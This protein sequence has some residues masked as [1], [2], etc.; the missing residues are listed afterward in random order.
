[1][2]VP[3]FEGGTDDVKA[4]K[5]S[6]SLEGAIPENRPQKSPAEPPACPRKYHYMSSNQ[7]LR[8]WIPFQP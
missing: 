2:M 3:I 6:F 8:P 4:E 7:V 1:M 5:V